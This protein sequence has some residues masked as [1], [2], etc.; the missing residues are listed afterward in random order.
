[1]TYSI[2]DGVGSSVRTFRFQ[3]NKQHIEKAELLN[4]GKITDAYHIGKSIRMTTEKGKYPYVW[5]KDDWLPLREG[6]VVMSE[7]NKL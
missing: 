3:P 1:M 7:G 4:E 5:I 6:H 2:S